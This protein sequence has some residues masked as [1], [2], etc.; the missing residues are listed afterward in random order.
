MEALC[1]SKVEIVWGEIDS[2]N[3]TGLMTASGRQINSDVVV[4]A[5][6]FNMG[7]VPRF[8]IVGLNGNNLRQVWAEELPTAYLS[9]TVKD[10][11]NYFV[12]M[13]PQSP[14]RHGSITGS[15]EYVTKYVHQLV[16]KLQTEG[17]SSLVPKG[18]VTKAW[19]AHAMK[20]MEKTVWVEKCASPFKNGSSRSTVVSLHPGSR[21]NYFN[22]LEKP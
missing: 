4:C 10:M 17:Y 3:E 21:L 9:V 11:P 5:T 1:S 15:V 14:L 22:L 2:F 19:L 6:G 8:P 20:W 7:F 12:M 13:G 16:Y 18:I